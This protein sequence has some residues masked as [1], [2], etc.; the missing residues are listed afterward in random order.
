MRRGYVDIDGEMPF[1]C[2][3]ADGGWNGWSLPYFSREVAKQVL[4]QYGEG[5]TPSWNGDYLVMWD[6][7][8][9]DGE[10]DR[11]RTLVDTVTVDGEMFYGIGAGSWIWSETVFSCGDCGLEFGAD[12]GAVS[13][14]HGIYWEFVCK[15]CDDKG[16]E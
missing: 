4:A 7:P 9:Y 15:G 13:V 2:V 6:A 10:T 8:E 1:P 11:E 3:I 5:Y 14:Q 16:G 12:D